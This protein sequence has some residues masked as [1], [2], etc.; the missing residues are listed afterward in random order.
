VKNFPKPQPL[1][2]SFFFF[3]FSNHLSKPKKILQPPSFLPFI[4]IFS[5]Y[6]PRK[7]LLFFF[8]F[9]F[10]CYFFSFFSLLFLSFFSTSHAAC[11]LSLG[12]ASFFSRSL[13]YPRP[14]EILILPFTLVL[15]FFLFLF[16]HQVL[17]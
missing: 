3:S 4:S 8:F 16:F 6:C 12:A 5:S 2:P 14:K 1:V 7:S 15:F 13:F 17:F 9:S 11:C 10:F